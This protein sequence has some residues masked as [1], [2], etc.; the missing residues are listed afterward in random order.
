MRLASTITATAVAAAWIASAAGCGDMLSDAVSK[1]AKE[2][3][4]VSDEEKREDVIR[5]GDA[6]AAEMLAEKDSVAEAKAWLADEQ[7]H[8]LWKVD[9]PTVVKLVDDLYAAGAVSVHA[10]SVDSI[11][12][13]QIAALFVVT[14]P[15]EAAGRAK[16]VETHNAFWKGYL[17]DVDEDELK[18]FQTRDAGQ[19]YLVVNFDL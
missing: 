1:A 11:G 9:R 5:E 3:A 7:K 8:K 4:V 2:Q 6:Q 13:G 15:T 17:Q 12:D 16:V 10:A 14:L 19:K 18:D